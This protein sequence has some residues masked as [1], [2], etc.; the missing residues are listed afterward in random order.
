VTMRRRHTAA[1]KAKVVQELLREEKSLREV[2]AHH[3]VHP[4][5]LA[6]WRATAIEGLPSLFE[7]GGR[8]KDKGEADR[9]RETDELYAE[10][11]RLTTKLAWIKKKSGL[12]I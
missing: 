1:F 9:E 5:Q 2:A 4:S 3:G 7:N 8:Q 6:K 11:G 12:D 10:I